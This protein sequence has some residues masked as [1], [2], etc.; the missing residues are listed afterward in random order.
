M[1][2]RE[3]IFDNF[4]RLKRGFD[5]PAS[6]LE[7]GPYPV[8][9]SSSISA[10]HKEFKVLGP[11]VV[12]G[13]SGSLGKVQYVPGAYWPHNT[14]LYVKDFRGN[15]PRYAYYLLQRMR[16][17]NFNSGAG[18]PTLNQNHLHKLRIRIPSRCIQERISAI[19]STY[20]ELIEN[21]KRRI[22]LLEK[23]TEEI[24]REWFVRLRFPGHARV[25]KLRGLPEGWKIDPLESLLADIIDY[26]GVTPTK[27]GSQWDS[28]GVIALSALNVKNGRL[29][30]LEDAGRVSETLYERWM[31]KKLRKFD[32]LLTSEAP[33]GQVYL[34]MDND[35]Y[36]LSQRLFGLRADTD[37]ILPVYL[38]HYLLFPVGQAQL[39]SRATGSTVGGIRQQLLRK[40]DVVVP[41]GEVFKSY[42]DFV[43]P[44]LQEGFHLSKQN[45]LLT[46]TRDLL[47]PRLISGKLSVE[48]LD[49][50]FP[51]S[52][53]EGLNA[54][55]TT[56]SFNA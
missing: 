25:R 14:A 49:I 8:V 48:N 28:D 23:L 9:A 37:R 2:W 35:K 13:R 6:R 32:I 22:A 5:L 33:L 43:L 17:E 55:S 42:S 1:N 12:T 31:R 10:Y 53:Q 4:V 7:T 16:L 54:E 36:V 56:T 30:K 26:R 18:V 51:P 11:G 39:N 27:L 34:L 21:N 52:M 45:D 46:K 29:I 3:D 47:L 50:Q 40:I 20:D 44:M 24:Y 19:L 15:F 41:T 38:Y